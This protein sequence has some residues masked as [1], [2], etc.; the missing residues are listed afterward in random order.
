MEFYLVGGAVRDK[1]LKINSKDKDF[2]VLNGSVEMVKLGYKQV[3]KSFLF[4]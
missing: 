2:V 3:G 4:Y 1:I